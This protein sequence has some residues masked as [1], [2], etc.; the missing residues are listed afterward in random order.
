M[1]KRCKFGRRKSGK[2]T[3]A[4]KY[5]CRTRKRTKYIKGTKTACKSLGGTWV[6]GKDITIRK[7]PGAGTTYR[8]RGYCRNP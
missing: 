2:K 7:G 8:R 1:A 6:P 4:G 5:R 3:K